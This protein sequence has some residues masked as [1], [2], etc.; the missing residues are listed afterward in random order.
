MRTQFRP[1]CRSSVS[2]SVVCLSIWAV[3]LTATTPA[4]HAAGDDWAAHRHHVAA[5]LGLTKKGGKTAETYGLEY[6][7]R[8][9]EP[10]A[11]G[12]WYEESSGDFDLESLGVFVNIFVTGNLPLMVGVG[13]ER[14][15]FGE[16]KY[17]GRIGAQYQFHPGSVTIAPAAWIDFVENGNELYFLGLTV[18]IGF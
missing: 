5:I 1:V 4:A 2:I 10:L 12:A 8:L 18:G 14:E 16:T 17:L 3:C 6:S 7:Y 15:L 11:A 13:A 9:N